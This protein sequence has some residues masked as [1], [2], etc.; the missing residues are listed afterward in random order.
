MVDCQSFFL[1]TIIG[2]RDH[3]AQC[4]RATTTPGA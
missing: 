2:I 4:R 3:A 1:I